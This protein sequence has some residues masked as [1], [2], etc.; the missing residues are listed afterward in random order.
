MYIH[1]HSY[2]YEF[3]YVYTKTNKG[4]RWTCWV[5][6]EG[7]RLVQRQRVHW[8]AKECMHYRGTSFHK[9]DPPPRTLQ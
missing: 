4:L 6:S 1:I 9:K 8:P 3:T 2:T 7:R 5:G